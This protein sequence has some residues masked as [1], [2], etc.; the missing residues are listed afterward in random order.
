MIRGDLC[1][2]DEAKFMNAI[3]IVDAISSRLVSLKGQKE[4]GEE[5][6]DSVYPEQLRLWLRSDFSRLSDEQYRSAFDLAI[7]GEK[8]GIVLP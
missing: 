2:R 7:N 4:C 6:A 3:S 8:Q 5:V 1:V